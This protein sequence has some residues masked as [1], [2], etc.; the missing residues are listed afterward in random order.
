MKSYSFGSCYGK[1]EVTADIAGLFTETYQ[2][3]GTVKYASE[4][5]FAGLQG[6]I[7]MDRPF[8]LPAYEYAIEEKDSLNKSRRKKKEV[9][10]DYGSNDDYDNIS[11]NGG[12][13]EEHLRVDT[14]KDAFDSVC[15]SDELAYAVRQIKGLNEELIIVEGL[16]IIEAIRLALNGLPHALKELKRVCDFY[17]RIAEHV[18]TILGS[19][20]TF[21][22]CMA[23]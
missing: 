6:R 12:V 10:I 17:P 21:E 16:N 23:L 14:I 3:G 22:E 7:D 20:L 13:C 4:I 19:G 11:R 5:I 2:K 18:Q 15:D 9:Y 8:N 1:D